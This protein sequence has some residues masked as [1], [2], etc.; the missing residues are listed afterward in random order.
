MNS[1]EH[2]GRRLSPAMTVA[3]ASA[4]IWGASIVA[5]ALLPR[6]AYSADT[7]P[8][9]MATIGNHQVT[10]QEVDTKVLQSLGASDLYDRRKQALDTLVD[11][12]IVDEAAKKAGMSRDAYLQHAA[13]APRVTDDEARKF[14]DQHKTQIQAQTGNKTFDQIKPLLVPALQRHQDIEQRSQLIAKLRADNHVKVNLQEPRVKVASA[15]HPANGAAT[16]PV[17]LV[18]FS[19]FQCPFCRAAETSLNAVRAKYGNNVRLVYMDFP[20]SFHPHSMDAAKAGRCAGEQDKFWQFHDALFTDQAKLEVNDLKA[21][22]KKIGL[23]SARFDSCFDKGKYEA[24]IRKDMAEGS[25]LGVTGTPTFFIN[26]RELVGAQPVE[27]F[28]EI[29]DDEIA[30]AKSPVNEAKAN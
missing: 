29:I 15:G 8:N 11:D 16:A 3:I 10:R 7:A 18:E 30:R 17:T 24:G 19:D 28:N 6:A 26:G 1:G 23:D 27:K 4:L 22:A 25:A 20:L 13:A 5:G 2:R 14:F 9:V 21:T 12:Y